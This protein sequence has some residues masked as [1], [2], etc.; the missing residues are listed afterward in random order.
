[1]KFK[2]LIYSSFITA[3]CLL[4]SIKLN[5]QDYSNSY[6]LLSGEIVSPANT[7]IT[8]VHILN[9]NNNELAVTDESG[10][11]SITMHPSNVLRISSV[12]FKTHY[13]TL[14]KQK[15]DITY[16]KITLQTV[17]IGL[18]NVDIVAKE[19][20]RAEHLFRPKPIPPPFTFG[21]QGVQHDVKTTVMNPISLLYNWLSKEGK[22]NKKLEELL[23]QEAVKQLVANRY[24]SDLIWE[25]TGYAGKE[26]ERFKEHCNLS[27][28][29]VTNASDY[30]FLLRIKDCYNSYIPEN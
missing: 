22:Q 19:E 24:E 17:T 18:K 20:Q 15:G 3:I 10:F 8:G 14:K 13:F 28:Y 23:K 25:L 16:V 12:G 5:A 27:E 30:D 7:P 6:I 11:F 29:F 21:Y 9:I 26:L 4:E 2:I 1:M